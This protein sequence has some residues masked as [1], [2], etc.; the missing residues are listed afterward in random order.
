MDSHSWLGLCLADQAN[1]KVDTCIS[2]WSISNR[3]RSDTSGEYR[4]Q[5]SLST[6]CTTVVGVKMSVTW[7]A[8]L[9]NDQLKL[10]LYSLIGSHWSVKFLELVGST[11]IILV[12]RIRPLWFRVSSREVGDVYSIHT[13]HSSVSIRWFLIVGIKPLCFHVSSR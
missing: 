11:V 3:C 7:A 6:P 13:S 8:L 1:V 4:P 10:Q 9:Y 2:E 12:V 5:S